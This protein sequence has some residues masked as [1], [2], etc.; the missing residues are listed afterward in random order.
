VLP[1]SRSRQRGQREELR[2]DSGRSFESRRQ[3]CSARNCHSAGIVLKRRQSPTPATRLGSANRTITPCSALE[4][5]QQRR[6]P[7]QIAGTFAPEHAGRCRR[8][9]A[10][11]RERPAVPFG[12]LFTRVVEFFAIRGP[13]KRLKRSLPWEAS[14]DDPRGQLVA[15]STTALGF[16]FRGNGG[17]VWNRRTSPLAVR[18]REGPLTEP[19]AG[20]Q[21]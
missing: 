11:Q 5:L 18:P 14:G 7:G 10:H 8:G 17:K 4:P 3:R 15:W 12:D 19:T 21:L 9:K 6:D 2:E 16:P 20:A 1:A 13:V